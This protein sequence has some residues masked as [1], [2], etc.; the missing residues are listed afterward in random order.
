MGRYRCTLIL[1]LL[2][3]V[4]SG[5]Q[6]SPNVDLRPFCPT[7][8][9]QGELP[10]CVAYSAAFAYSIAYN[11]HDN[12]T[13]RTQQDQ[14][15]FSASFLYNLL[16]EP[17]ASTTPNALSLESLLCAYR[18]TGTLPV[19]DFPE[20]ARFQYYPDA[21][22]RQLA[23]AWKAAYAATVWQKKDSLAPI[24]LIEQILSDSFPLIA[25]CALYQSLE[26]IKPDQQPWTMQLP[27]KY[28]GAHSLLIVAYDQI[29]QEFILL[30]SRGP[31][32][33]AHGF[34]RIQYETLAQI[35]LSLA[36]LAPPCCSTRIDQAGWRGSLKHQTDSACCV[37]PLP[38]DPP[39]A[40]ATLYIDK[41][42][43]NLNIQDSQSLRA[44]SGTKSLVI[45]VI[46]KGK[47]LKLEV[48][49]GTTDHLQTSNL[50]LETT[51]RVSPVQL[52]YE[53]VSNQFF[54]LAMLNEQYC[55]LQISEN[56]QLFAET[57]L[58]DTL[59]YGL[60]AENVSMIIEEKYVTL[61]GQVTR[62]EDGCKISNPILLRLDQN[63]YRWT[64]QDGFPILWADLKIH[65]TGRIAHL[66][67]GRYAL[68][69]SYYDNWGQTSGFVWIFDALVPGIRPANH[70]SIEQG[71][72]ALIHVS[73][74][75]ELASN[76][77]LLCGIIQHKKDN[78]FQQAALVEWQEYTQSLNCI[79]KSRKNG[80]WKCTATQKDDTWYCRLDNKNR[81]VVAALQVKAE[82]LPRQALY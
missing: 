17:T 81:G 67:D 73:Q 9:N 50:L 28:V 11:V 27:D 47:G 39:K 76:H 55:L 32:W 57:F 80:Q 31:G 29:K 3:V 16:H 77:F 68:P 70:I 60:R 4:R 5:A 25:Q 13:N 58:P 6:I 72:D 10:A 71:A 19:A 79:W 65:N 24:A 21:G 74:I 20:S 23:G 38:P 30:N 41:T 36:V 18:K 78:G 48:L 61:W 37:L 75:L 15:R 82:Y 1:C 14:R 35:L 34:V 62:F 12:R 59:W 56:G 44:A 63:E 52:E 8:A 22:Q 66:K 26:T 2:T 42:D 46:R 43:N 64:P 49:E 45:S 7:A 69:G 54:L 51:G 40:I 53:P 33:C